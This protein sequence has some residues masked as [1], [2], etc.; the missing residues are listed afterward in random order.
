MPIER[1]GELALHRGGCPPP[2][3]RE[4]AATPPHRGGATT[5]MADGLRYD[6]R[7]QRPPPQLAEQ[8][9]GGRSCLAHG[10]SGA[11]AASELVEATRRCVATSALPVRVFLLAGA[12]PAQPFRQLDGALLTSHWFCAP[13]KARRSVT[14]TA[15]LA[16]PSYGVSRD[17]S[18]SRTRR[19]GGYAQNPGKIRRLCGVVAC[20]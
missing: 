3:R 20:G 5:S 4:G 19:R 2:P 7:A 16:G 9:L 8:L 12:P 14:L 1:P 11:L 6:V 17:P 10:S 18:R 13:S 15:S